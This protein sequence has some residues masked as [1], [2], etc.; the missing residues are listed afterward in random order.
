[1]RVLTDQAKSMGEFAMKAATGVLHPKQIG[2]LRVGDGL[3]GPSPG[4]AASRTGAGQR[5]CADRYL[6]AIRLV[7]D[8]TLV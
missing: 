1:M 2:K 3:D 6:L 7:S 5:I 4:G 8:S